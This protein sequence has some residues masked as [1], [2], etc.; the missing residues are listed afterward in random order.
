[1]NKKEELPG[2]IGFPACAEE[3]ELLI[4][5][6]NLPYW[7]FPGSTYF[8]T[9][10]L[11][12]GILSE[13]ERNIVL[14]AIKHFHQIR[15][16]ITCAVVM[17]DHVHILLKPFVSES[18]TDFSLSKIMQG[19]KGFSAREINKSRG[20]KGI[21][22]LDES[23]DHIVRDYDEYL[24]KLNYIRDN[25]AKAELCQEL[26]DYALLWEPGEPEE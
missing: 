9:F 7:Q 5:Q 17:P 20:T 3:E 2:G 26:E 15:Y 1:M 6:R 14:N 16:W 25:P 12:S 4:T 11:K 21:L 13:D 24:E 23:Y 18:G 10:R 19:I 22:W 8:I